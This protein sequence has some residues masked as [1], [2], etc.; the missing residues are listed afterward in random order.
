MQLRDSGINNV[1]DV[2]QAG[3][4]SCGRRQ[5]HRSTAELLA[6]LDAAELAGDRPRAIALIEQIYAALDRGHAMAAYGHQEPVGKVAP[7]TVKIRLGGTS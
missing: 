3:D 2:S 5:D 4:A 1:V 6:A 7:A